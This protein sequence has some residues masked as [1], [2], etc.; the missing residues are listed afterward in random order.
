MK[1]QKQHHPRTPLHD[2]L[3]EAFF[4]FFNKGIPADQSLHLVF[5]NHKVRDAHQRTELATRFYG[6]IRF[7]RP[8]SSALGKE[9]TDAIN[10]PGIFISAWKKWIRLYGGEPLKDEK[11]GVAAKMRN[12][13]SIRRLRES[14]PDWLDEF[15]AQQR[16]ET[17]WEKISH[18]LNADPVIFLRVNTLH[19]ATGTAA[20]ELEKEHIRVKQ[21]QGMNDAL[22][23]EGYHNVFD[24]ASFHNGS[25]EVQDISSQEV[26][27]LLDVHAGMRVC[28]AC[29][30]NGGKT[31]HLAALMKNKGKIIA[32]DISEKKL[33]ELRRRCTR[34]G[35]DI[36]ETRVV[37]NTRSIQRLEKSFDRLL[38][39]VPCSGSG[40]M[41]RNPDIRWRLTR[42]DIHHLMQ[43]QKKLLEQ[44]SPLVKP[45]GK[46]MYSSCSIFPCEGEE[47]V[48]S[49]VEMHSN[50]W[51]IEKEVRIDPFDGKGDGFFMALLQKNG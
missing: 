27:T 34:N 37:D 21:V 22:E 12:Y 16:G 11:D 8:I 48:K 28:D 49:F 6:I 23:V 43:L 14:F 13:L 38:L 45:G 41:R 9:V 2:L 18:A 17:T 7:W 19:T 32:L 46:M 30:G 35:A 10:E 20:A 47:Q 4:Q 31:L 5:R 33:D 36:V 15:G 42:E 25:F 24:T 39:D 3:S 40:V 50:E 51:K 44:Y 26:S 29:A 1:K